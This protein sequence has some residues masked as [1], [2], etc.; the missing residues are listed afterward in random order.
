MI[1]PLVDMTSVQDLNIVIKCCVAPA[2]YRN[3]KCGMVEVR[4]KQSC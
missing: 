2:G 4:V 1:R 3:N